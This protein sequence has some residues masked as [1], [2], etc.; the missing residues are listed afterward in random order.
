METATKSTP[1]TLNLSPEILAS[2][3][4]Y[5]KANGNCSRSA[6]ARALIQ[7]ALDQMGETR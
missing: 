5:A 4:A 1:I 6:A 3:D 7:K 2:L